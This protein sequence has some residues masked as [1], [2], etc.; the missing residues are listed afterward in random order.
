[1]LPVPA[2]TATQVAVGGPRP[3]RLYPFAAQL[4]R[5]P[6]PAR[7]ESYG[8]LASVDSARTRRWITVENHF[9]ERELRAIPQ[10]AWIERRLEHL[11][12]APAARGAGEFTTERILYLTATG[13]R[14]PMLI[15]YR[16]DLVR[17]GDRPAILTV[18][19]PRHGGSTPTLEPRARVWMELGGV[20]AEAQVPGEAQ[21]EEA[22]RGVATLSVRSEALRDLIAAAR[23]L[24]ERGYTRR[25]R[26]AIYGRGYGGLLA[27]ALLTEFPRDFAV[28][29]PTGSWAEYRHPEPSVCYPPTLI[30]TARHDGIVRPW[31]GYE[32]AAAL[33]SVQACSSQ[34]VLIRIYDQPI[35]PRAAASARIEGDADALAFAARWL[36]VPAPPK[37]R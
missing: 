35:E 34:P 5:P 25:G 20:Y 22:P 27:G 14:L 26:L 12:R 32:L 8:W 28:A 6:P 18:L 33:Q 3:P 13:K 37:A 11:A 1:M 30:A 19:R 24:F 15:A 29:L 17:D 9:G 23:Y 21:F 16:R 36:G 10:R 2:P 7:E 4:K 31:R